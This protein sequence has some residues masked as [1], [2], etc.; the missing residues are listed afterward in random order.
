ME[1]VKKEVWIAESTE[2][3]P[4]QRIAWTSR[5]DAITGGVVTFH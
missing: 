1:G 4:D 3:A 5:G 2:Q